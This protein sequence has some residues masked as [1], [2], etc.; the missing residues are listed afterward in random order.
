MQP[1][2]DNDVNLA[3]ASLLQVSKGVI[4]ESR[5]YIEPK[6]NVSI[7][8]S[9][10]KKILSKQGQRGAYRYF[11]NEIAIPKLGDKEVLHYLEKIELIDNAG[12][13][14]R[15]F[16]R[17]LKELPV[18]KGL[19]FQNISEIRSDVKDFF[20][21]TET[22]AARKPGEHIP[23]TFEGTHIKTAIVYVAIYAR[24]EKE[25]ARPYLRRALL[26]RKNGVEIIFFISFSHAIDFARKII[27]TLT[28]TYGMELIKNTEKDFV[29][30]NENFMC[31][32]VLTNSSNVL[33]PQDDLLLHDLAV[34]AIKETSSET[35]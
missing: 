12:L 17:E 14:T 21:Y 31:A 15:L 29:I 19:V 1:S 27:D 35:G 28:K 33:G 24:M 3:R 7:D 18:I 26:N 6:M 13:F 16:L 25:G 22:V 4:P 32:T 9:L 8:L 34:N 10:V 30:D 20:E 11:V 23:L 5:M 2:K